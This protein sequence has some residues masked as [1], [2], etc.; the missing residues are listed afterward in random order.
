MRKEDNSCELIVSYIWTSSKIISTY[1]PESEFFEN[2]PGIF[3]EFYW[4]F[5]GII[6]QF[7]GNS[8]G[9]L[10]GCMVGGVL[11]RDVLG[12]LWEFFGNSLGISNCILTQKRMQ[13]SGSLWI[14]CGNNSS[15]FNF[16]KLFQWKPFYVTFQC[17]C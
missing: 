15:F 4:N 3:W 5:Q 17:G 1:K 10:W 9:I 12:I 16:F 13:G 2:F 7:L 6:W 14:F 8:L 11:I